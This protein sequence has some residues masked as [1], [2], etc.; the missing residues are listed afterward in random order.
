MTIK[1]KRGIKNK[2]P[3]PKEM[4]KQVS[5]GATPNKLGSIDQSGK[6]PKVSL[7]S[8]G[9]PPSPKV[10]LNSVSAP[11]TPKLSSVSPP[12]TPKL[13]LNSIGP[14]PSPKILSVSA[15][16]SPKLSSLSPPMTPKLTLS[17]VGPPPSPKVLSV[18]APSSPQ[19]TLNSIGPPPSPNKSMLNTLLDTNNIVR[20]ATSFTSATSKIQVK[21]DTKL[22]KE[23]EDK[24]LI[25]GW[26]EQE[27]NLCE[28]YKGALAESEYDSNELAKDITSFYDP[29][30]FSQ[31]DVYIYINSYKII[32]NLDKITHNRIY[33][34]YKDDVLNVPQEVFTLINANLE[35][36]KVKF[37]DVYNSLKDEHMYLTKQKGRAYWD[38]ILKSLEDPNH[39]I[40]QVKMPS[41]ILPPFVEKQY[42]RQAQ[43]RNARIQREP[44]PESSINH[45]T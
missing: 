8:I 43:M 35:F 24:K 12:T 44:D 2:Q 32:D 3:P 21:T 5:L 34:D 7:S 37:K 23:F 25:L 28:A 39:P 29:F 20:P 14:P 42:M 11:T 16:T 15:P 18:S 36:L 13:S 27:N 41:L 1:W 6:S 4:R 30:V 19:A 10:S 40:N 22:T 17:S 26:W 33:D 38:R 31:S 45:W 9:P